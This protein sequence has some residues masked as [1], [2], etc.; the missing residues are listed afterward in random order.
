VTEAQRPDWKQYVRE[1]LAPLALEAELELEMIE[2]MAQHLDAVF[3]EALTNGASPQQ[4]LDRAKAHI[5]DWH[6]LECELVRAKRPGKALALGATA[7][8]HP[9]HWNRMTSRKANTGEIVMGSLMQDLRY[10]AR[11]LSKSKAVTAVAVL[12]LALGIGANTAI[13]SLVDEVLLKT[14]PVRNPHELVLFNWLSGPTFMAQSI[15]GTLD[16]DK[17]TG[18]STS[19]SFSTDTFNRFREQAQT[20]T[21]IFAFAEM[22]RL[23]VNV[24][25]QAEIAGGQI[26][27][28]EY[29]PAL[30]VSAAIGRPITQDDDQ[31][32]AHPVAVLSHRYW[33]RRFGKDPQVLGKTIEINGVV[34]TIVG[35][36]P[37]GFDGTLQVGSSPDLTIPL[38]MEPRISA[39]KSMLEDPSVWWLQIMGRLKPGATM[40]QTSASLESIF[41]QSATDGYQAAIARKAAEDDRHFHLSLRADAL[42]STQESKKPDIPTLRAGS[43]SQGLTDARK[44]YRLSL[45]ILMAVVGLVLLIAC[46]NVA[47]LLM[48]RASARR[49]EIAV[50]LALGASRAR[51]IRQL[52]TESVL[53]S[54]LGG[55]LG[56]LL[57]Y[58]GKDSLLSLRPW[59]GSELQLDLT[60]DLHVLGFTAAVS[61][62][63][64]IL[65]G[66]APAFRATRTD[67]TAALKDNGRGV[68]GG[69]FGLSKA[70]VIAQ[71]AMSLLLLI[72]AGL[73]I[74]TLQNLHSVGLGFNPQHLLLFRVDPGLSGYKKD[75]ISPLYDRMVEQ[76]EAV[77]G[78]A[79][80][81]ISRHALLSGSASID[82]AFVEGEP[83]P[84]GEPTS[85]SDMTWLQRVRANF[86]QTM[87]IP[88]VMGREFSP[89]DDQ[90]APKVAVINQAMARKHFG[91]DNPIGKRLGFDGP[92]HAGEIEIVGVAG[93]AKY[94]SVR[95]KTPYTVYLPYSQ[96]PK[97]L[98]GM[99]FEVRTAGDPAALTPLI[100]EAVHKVDANLPMFGVKTQ[101]QQAEDS[102]SGERLFATLSSIFG[103]LATLL[104]CIG[105]YGVMSFAVARRTNEI[106]IRMALGAK[107]ADVVR[108][109]VR[110]TMVLVFIGVVIGLGAAIGVTRFI[111]SMLFG[112]SP[113][114]PLTISVGVVLML[115]GAALAGYVPARRASRVAPVI[116][117]RCE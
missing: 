3:D 108:M 27:S 34:F 66:L 28:G 20:L 42:P 45:G 9:P 76:I 6:L 54:V 82:M 75:Q 16:R 40:A 86:F 78:V 56:C 37:R 83:A 11:M 35:V 71:V 49:R 97:S 105:L 41:Q 72:G 14:L 91:D 43:G 18:L 52:L 38:A 96:D 55:A 48:S 73:F 1:H 4:S 94:H 32:S 101:L 53:L 114:D 50:R 116:A 22:D 89:Q 30:G 26:V 84:E 12:S 113:T 33:N 57:A 10:G 110:E 21:D 7:R 106:G 47:T 87:E 79:R 92:E 24:D 99:T 65:F 2:E 62:L 90:H 23:N 17:P 103:A 67:L 15:S 60:I 109:I 46:A 58:W 111:G 64:G 68:I 112:L 36:A 100:R 19:T 5:R 74:R 77:P 8:P 29:Y 13:F 63:T 88:I 81:T 102:V 44:E 107:A 80:V 85:M 31:P 93:D 95:S 25:G 61:L 70:L 59:G 115:A 98:G 117:L 39:G 51:L 69:R 104:A